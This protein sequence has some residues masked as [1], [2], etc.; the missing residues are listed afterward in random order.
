VGRELTR[1][2]GLFTR[3][4]NPVSDLQEVGWAPEPVSS[5]QKISSSQ[6]ILSSERPASPYTNWAIPAHD[7]KNLLHNRM[8][9]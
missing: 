6:E 8:Y 4:N 3:G 7:F 1:P 2:Y 5:V 9:V